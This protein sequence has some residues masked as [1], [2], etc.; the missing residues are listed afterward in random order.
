M[1]FEPQVCIGF[2]ALEAFRELVRR[3]ELHHLCLV[4]DDNTWDALGARV[5][6]MM[7]EEEIGVESVVLHGDEVRADED[8]VMQMLLPVLSRDCV[9]VAVGSG[10]LTDITRFVSHRT[11]RRFISLPTAP[12]VDAFASPSSPLVVRGVKRTVPAQLPIAIFADLEALCAAPLEMVAAGFGDILGKYIC[13][14]DWKLA[15]LLWDAPYDACAVQITRGS[16]ERV[17]VHASAIGRGEPAAIKILMEALIA[18]GLSMARVG[19]SRPASGSEHHLSHFWEMQL[20]QQGRPSIL[21]GAKVG[22]GAVLMAREYERIRGISREEAVSRLRK[23][24]IPDKAQQTEEIEKAYGPIAGAILESHKPFLDMSPQRF[25]ALKRDIAEHWTEIQEIAATVPPA[26]SLSS[27]LQGTSG[28]ADPCA[29][30]LSPNQVSM[31][32][33]AAHYIRNRFTV[34]KLELALGM[35]P[36]Q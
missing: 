23:S 6:K 26:R 5:E 16:L 17:M 34:R 27:L 13:L 25:E 7:R 31:A 11:G 36:L 18:S 30:G 20:L 3:R 24:E 4:A 8:H 21:H 19:S 33:R 12:S 14:A 1:D 15:Y 32:L 28:Q 29:L 35:E 10:T 9:Y 22:A 2:D